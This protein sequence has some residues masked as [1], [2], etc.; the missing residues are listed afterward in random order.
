LEAIEL[1]LSVSSRHTPVVGAD[2]ARDARDLGGEDA[3]LLDHRV[4][5]RRQA[6]ELSLQWPAVDIEPHGLQQIAARHRGDRI[7]DRVGRPQQVLDQGVDRV[8][9]LAPGAI[10]QSELDALAGLAL[11]ADDLADIF[12]LLRHPLVGGDDLIE[13]IG[14][15]AA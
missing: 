3:E 1:T 2:L 7:G 9:H 11:A 13:G 12:E 6:Q 4:D 5:D 14:D 8:L 10:R 15:L